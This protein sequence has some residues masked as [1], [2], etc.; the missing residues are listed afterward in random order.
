MGRI[1]N[2]AWTLLLEGDR[3]IAS[4]GAD[5]LFLIDE[6]DAAAAHKLHDAW[7]GDR[8]DSLSDD[9]TARVLEQLRRMGALVP[10]QT[11]NAKLRVA[12]QAHGAAAAIADALLRLI[13]TAPQLTLVKKDPELVLVIRASGQLAETATACAEL[14]APHLL[15]DV[16]YQRTLSL[17]PLV[18]PGETACLMCLTGRIARAWGDPAA[19]PAP[20]A[21][22][23]SAFAAALLFEE[24]QRFRELGS[25][26]QLVERTVFI[27]LESWAT[28]SERVHRLPWCPRCFSDAQPYGTGAFALPWRI[29]GTSP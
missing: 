20:H 5:S 17:G 9:A 2:P 11:T 1:R 24:A 23:K 29:G 8:L 16:A 19:P 10:A 15:L 18:F 28:R 3:L 7:H 27:D 4:A 25:C 13:E 21:T 14:K 6:L 22:T 12:I 26:P